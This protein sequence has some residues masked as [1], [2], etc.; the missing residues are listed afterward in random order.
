MSRPPSLRPAS[1]EILTISVHFPGAQFPL[2][3]SV[4]SDPDGAAFVG[5]VFTLRSDAGAWI[6]QHSGPPLDTAPPPAPSG[7]LPA[8]L[9]QLLHSA[10]P[11]LNPAAFPVP[12]GASLRGFFVAESDCAAERD[13][14]LGRHKRQ[15]LLSNLPLRRGLARPGGNKV[16]QQLVVDG[17]VV[18][19]PKA[20]VDALQSATPQWVGL[21][22]AALVTA[23]CSQAQG[24]GASTTS[25]RWVPSTRAAKDAAKLKRSQN[26]K[27][28][29]SEETQQQAQPSGGVC[30]HADADADALLDALP[31]F[32]I[33]SVVIGLPGLNG[34]RVLFRPYFLDKRNLD[35]VLVQ[36]RKTHLKQIMQARAAS[37]RGN[38]VATA[39]A[40]AILRAVAFGEELPPMDDG[41]G[42]MFPPKGDDGGGEDDTG[43]SLEDGGIDDTDSLVRL[44]PP[45]VSRPCLLK[46][47]GYSQ[48]KDY[49]K[50]LMGGSGPGAA[51]GPFGGMGEDGD[52]EDGAHNA[53]HST[54]HSGGGPLA[55][56]LFPWLSLPSTGGQATGVRLEPPTAAHAAAAAAV[57]TV[58]GFAAVTM[59]LTAPL[60]DSI[61]ALLAHTKPGR[62]LLLTGRWTVPTDGPAIEETFTAGDVNVSTWRDVRAN[63]ATALRAARQKRRRG[64]RP[65]AGGG[66]PTKAEVQDGGDAGG[67]LNAASG[68]SGDGSAADD[69][70]DEEENPLLEGVGEDGDAMP[71]PT[72]EEMDQVERPLFVG[73]LGGMLGTR[74]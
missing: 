57:G 63:A 41:S 27:A 13:R 28:A 59:A 50:D 5:N 19:S 35:A 22:T 46:T 38:A 32:S 30:T 7:L 31:V 67:G 69:D 11:Q 61:D 64:M 2:S 72:P 15:A 24:D 36:A 34:R 20:A 60:G 14:L 21:S 25:I 49:M 68:F 73:D 54:Q 39:R 37:R 62:R 42:G 55:K 66:E 40:A 3:L 29:A 4:S 26:S 18:D 12:P 9:R 51:R 10:F 47:S 33:A 58:L 44:P 23:R 56:V 45:G 1:G 17:S 74:L 52:D 71:A 43:E 65:I 53:P 16:V 8:L 48:V 70:D 6:A